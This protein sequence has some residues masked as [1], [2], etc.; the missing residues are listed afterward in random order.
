VIRQ[1]RPIAAVLVAVA[2][3]ATGCGGGGSSSTTAAP[4][5]PKETA[6]KLPSL[7]PGWRAHRD[8]KVGYAIGLPPGWQ[9]IGQRRGVLLRSPDHLVAVTLAANRDPSVFETPPEK[10]ATQALGGLAGFKV[11]LDPGK[12][13]P[14]KGTPLKAVQTSASGAQAGG[15]KENAT[16]V[17]LRRDHVVNYTAA[18]LVNSQQ[19]GASVDRAVALRMIQ[20]LRDQPVKEAGAGQR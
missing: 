18:V 7:P 8:G 19:A 14:F 2:L 20:T 6:Q 1:R 3:G 17:V 12:V 11:P 4:P 10:F 5:G 13:S 15:L 16:L 9:A